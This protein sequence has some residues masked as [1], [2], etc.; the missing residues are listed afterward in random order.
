MKNIFFLI[1]LI[2]ATISCQRETTQTLDNNYSIN[3]IRK[4]IPENIYKKSETISF[5]NSTKK[6]K[7]FQISYN[8]IKLTDLQ[9][10]N[11]NKEVYTLQ[12]EDNSLYFINL[13]AQP[14]LHD[15][16]V[17]ERLYVELLTSLNQG[18]TASIIIDQNGETWFNSKEKE[19]TLLGK[20]FNDVYIGEI[21]KEDEIAC[22]KL[23]YS[24]NEGV[25]GFTD[26]KGDLW[27][28]HE[29]K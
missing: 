5:I 2:L 24:S 1:I 7:K 27:V 25:V 4:F 6:I 13:S 26:E 17:Y 10:R 19:I 29:I 9:N 18:L 28:L 23:Y 22:N 21:S 3:L 20:S 16:L 12:E 15:N 11:L 14:E 8:Q